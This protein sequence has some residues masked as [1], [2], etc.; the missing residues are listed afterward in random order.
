MSVEPSKASETE[1]PDIE[2]PDFESESS[3]L[4][5]L[6]ARRAQSRFGL[7]VGL[8]FVAVL[9]FLAS[10]ILIWVGVFPGLIALVIAVPLAIAGVR[11]IR[12][13]EAA[14]TLPR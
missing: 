12:G 2:S 14:R 6:N 1:S 11:L 10:F 4:S 3:D 13:S 8:A 9:L 5:A 7:G